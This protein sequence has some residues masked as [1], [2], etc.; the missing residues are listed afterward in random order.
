MIPC[1][2]GKEEITGVTR[3]PYLGFEQT[4]SR[5]LYELNLGSPEYFPVAGMGMRLNSWNRNRILLNSFYVEINDTWQM[6]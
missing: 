5:Q 4:L 6:E 2:Q 3:H 1:S